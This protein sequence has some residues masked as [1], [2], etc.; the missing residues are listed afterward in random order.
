MKRRTAILLSIALIGYSISSCVKLKV[1]KLS[2]RDYGRKMQNEHHVYALVLPKKLNLAGEPIPMDNPDVYERMDQAFLTYT[3]LYKSV[4][5]IIKKANKYF[6]A[7]E[8]T[9]SAHGVPNDFK[10]LAVA[11]SDLDPV[12]VSHSDAKGMWQFM[13]NTAE[14]YG[15]EITETVDERYNVELETEAFCR[16]I[17]R[18]KKE[19][20]SWALAAASY[21]AGIGYIKERLERQDVHSFYD[22]YCNKAETKQ[23]VFHIV[24]IKYIMEDPERYGFRLREKDK[25]KTVPIQEFKV[26]YPI[27]DLAKWAKQRGSNYKLLKL[28]N[29]W[30]L[31]YKLEH[32]NKKT[33]Y[34]KIPRQV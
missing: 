12:A 4:I 7:I 6:P 2:D 22:M 15:M 13:K 1:D 24:A 14:E 30:L 21:N 33:Y 27:D 26:D 17:L 9:L 5:R 20:G 8:A 32:K 29:P 3:Y 19:L 11:E 16:Y 25:Y 10:Y 34:I 31:G 18:A 23:Y 28:Y